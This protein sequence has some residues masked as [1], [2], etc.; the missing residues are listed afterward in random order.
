LFFTEDFIESLRT[1][2]VIGTIQ[3]VDLVDVEVSGG[4]GWNDEEREVL[5]EAYALII[6]MLEAG[7]L[8]LESHPAFLK[9][10][11]TLRDCPEIMEFLRNIRGDC[12]LESTNLRLSSLRSRFR[13][14]LGSGF[15]YEFSQGDLDRVQHLIN[16]LREQISKVKTLKD[17]HQQ[18]LLRRLEKLQAEMHKKVSDLDRFWGLNR[19]GFHGGWLV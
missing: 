6:E 4:S 2:P 12:Q 11:G 16:E 3:I 9:L 14:K 10:S 13:V 15:I 17:E 8:A 5:F 7:I 19:P 1:D 18:R